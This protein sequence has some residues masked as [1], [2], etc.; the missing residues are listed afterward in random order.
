LRSL[1]GEAGSVTVFLLIVLFA[2][3]IFSGVLLDIARIFAAYQELG[4]SLETA[5]RSSFA[6]C[7]EVMSAEYGLYANN[8]EK[9]LIEHYLRLNLYP[10]NEKIRFINFTD[11]H[12]KIFPDQNSSITENKVF[13]K[14]IIRCM[15]KKEFLNAAEKIITGLRDAS[16]LWDEN[17]RSIL[18]GEMDSNYSQEEYSSDEEQ[19]FCEKKITDVLRC[20]KKELNYKNMNEQ[21]LIYKN[22]C[23]Q[24]QIQIEEKQTKSSIY[25]ID[26]ELL[27]KEMIVLSLRKTQEQGSI[28]SE[29]INT[30]KKNISNL[31]G[32]GWEKI[33]IA[34]YIL[35]KYTYITSSTKREHYF[36]LGEIEYI[37]CGNLSEKENVLEVFSRIWL[38]RF[39]V[40]SAENFIKSEAASPAIRLAQAVFIG[41][42]KANNETADIYEGK[43][44]QFLP[45][46]ESIALS[47]S[48]YLRVFLLIQAEEVQLNRAREL[49]QSSIRRNHEEGFSLVDYFE[50]Y[51]AEVSATID[52]WFVPGSRKMEISSQKH[53]EY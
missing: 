15:Q 26:K 51:T 32:K 48:D 17:Y 19:S 49:I 12:V 23:V 8:N 45:A 43:K 6:S 21:D 9:A 3:V 20:L 14:Q 33:S 11:L 52:L 47:Y 24:E 5:L 39:A 10:E 25:K 44:V 13:K 37:L 29:Q 50:S 30:L 35:D 36:E 1:R 46:K 38:I 28:I 41:I 53:M 16:S 22:L 42:S 27:E 31:T 18:D 34:E 2:L 7:H 40:N 4:E